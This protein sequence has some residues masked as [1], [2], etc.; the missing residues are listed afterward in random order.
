MAVPVFPQKLSRF[1]SAKLEDLRI[2]YTEDSPEY[3]GL[4]LQYLRD[5]REDVATPKY[6]VKHYE[7][8]LDESAA[9]GGLPAGLERLYKRTLVIEPTLACVAHCRFCLRQNYEKNTLTESQLMDVARYCGNEANRDVINEV[10]ITGGD[11]LMIP[12]RIELL[13]RALMKHAENV[14]VVRI[15]TRLP[16]QDPLLLDDDALGVFRDKPSLRF[17]LA[18][19]INHPVEFFPETDEVLNRIL[20]L[21]VR[22]YAQNVLLKGI[23]D[24]I[25]TLVELYDGLRRRAVEAH[26][27]FHAVPLRGTH[28][29]RTSLERGLE[30]ACALTNCGAISGRAKPIF[31]AMTDIGKV[32]FYEGSVA[33]RRDGEVLLRSG[34]SMA[35]RLAWN[36]AWALPET[37]SVDGS[38][39][40]QVWYLDGEG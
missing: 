30:L 32:T 20:D 23:N 15:A 5:P 6:N 36:P 18:T 34:Y 12:R 38:G 22:V 24:R 17:E 29:F 11:P 21:G 19:Q 25:E 33:G 4:A 35:D 26:Y 27:L 8:G 1:L 40:L 7:A 2:R 28:H 16:T 9:P 39:K 37:A 10:L 13:L 31:T 3:R 14:R